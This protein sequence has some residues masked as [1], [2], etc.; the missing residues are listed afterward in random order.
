MHLFDIREQFIQF[1]INEKIHKYERKCETFY[2]LSENLGDYSVG[3][4]ERATVCVI[5]NDVCL[6]TSEGEMG[7]RL[8]LTAAQQI[9]R[10]EILS[11]PHMITSENEKP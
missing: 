8:S 1:K 4:R 7:F 10:G 2:C 3:T 6:N 9:K 5:T 11:T